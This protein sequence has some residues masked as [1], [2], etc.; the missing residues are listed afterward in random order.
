MTIL[1]AEKNW[2]KQIAECIFFLGLTL[3]LIYVLL[4]KSAYSIPSEG[5]L[6]RFTFVL[7]ALKVMLSK[8]TKKEWIWLML[9]G[10]IALVS[11]RYSGRNEMLRLVVMCAAM[12]DVEAK[13]VFR[14]ALWFTAVGCLSLVFLAVCGIFGSVTLTT[15]YRKTE[16]TRYVLGLGHPNQ[17][18][19]V[20]WAIVTFFMYCYYDK[21]KWLPLV[22]IQLANTGLFLLTDSKGGFLAV[23]VAVIGIA[24][25][26]YAKKLR[27]MKWIYITVIAGIVLLALMSLAVAYY[28]KLFFDYG[29][30]KHAPYFRKINNF[31]QKFFTGRMFESYAHEATTIR[32]FKLFSKPDN[33]SY[34]DMGF[35]KLFYWYGYIPGAIYV[36]VNCLLVWYSFKKKNYALLVFVTDWAMYNFLEAHEITEY[37]ACNYLYFLFGAFFSECVGANTGENYAFYEIPK[38]VIAYFKD[39]NHKL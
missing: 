39:F 26:I 1:S 21:M 14:Y 32:D 10:L 27:D 5:M 16:E 9:L 25:M 13:K 20:F 2:M 31:D 24:V 15:I 33:V 18:H 23:T 35:Y 12:K 4:Y 38:V 19:G 6:F 8:Y 3:E 28:G 17:L 29:G 22:I 34:M 7:F 37:L 36:F 30:W 11:Y